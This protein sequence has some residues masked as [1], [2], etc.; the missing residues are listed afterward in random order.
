MVS[1]PFLMTPTNNAFLPSSLLLPFSP[2]VDTSDLVTQLAFPTGCRTLLAGTERGAIRGYR[3]P[4]S[5]EAPQEA[6]FFAG[7]VSRMVLAAQETALFVASEDGSLFMFDVKDKQA[8]LQQ[9]QQGDRKRE[10][11]PY[12]DEVLVTKSD[13]EERAQ[14]MA[15]LE[16]KVGEWRGGEM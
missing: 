5:G 10:D 12:A 16:A 3:Y 15:D 7:P 13:L 8:L 14:H 6:R 1:V 2:Q 11:I 9:Q 4:L